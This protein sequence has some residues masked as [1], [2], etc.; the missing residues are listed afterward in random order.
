MA[1]RTRFLIYGGLILGITIWVWSL[2]GVLFWLRWNSIKRPDTPIQ[3]LFPYREIRVG[4]D[5]SFPP[6]AVANGN[7]LSGID[8]DIGLHLGTELG[9]PVRFINMGYDGLYDALIADQADILI[10]ALTIDYNRS[11]DVLFTVPYYNAGLWLVSRSDKPIESMNK[12]SYHSLAFEF[13]SDANLLA[14]G[15]LRRI[16]PFQLDPY[17]TPNYA[18]D[19]VRLKLSDA[20]LVDSTSAR[21]YLRAHKGFHAKHSQITDVLYSIAI[22]TKRGKTWEAVNH[23]LQEMIGQR[24]IEAILNKWL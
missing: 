9:I 17:E 3:E 10:S 18:L 13:G 6:F 4:V 1:S 12:L 11:G 19:A 15:W 14:R 8:I 20:A 24:T 16:E 2:S 22:S 7:T 21:L 23:A 5:A